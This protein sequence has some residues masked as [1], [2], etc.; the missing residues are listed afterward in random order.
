MTVEHYAL[1]DLIAV[2]AL[3]AADEHDTVRVEAHAGECAVCREELASLR[4]A[5]GALAVTVPQHEPSP[6]LKA[7]LMETVRAEAPARA[8]AAGIGTPPQP[9]RERARSRRPFRAFLRPWPV[10]AALGC[11][12]ALLLGWNIALQTG[13]DDPG[14][15]D[16]TALSVAGTADAPGVT[17][18]IVYVP[19]EDTAVVRLSRLPQ[20]EAGEAYQLW[21]LRDGQPPRSAGLFEQT[22]PA[23]ARSVASGSRG[24][25]AWP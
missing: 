24:A 21:I 19:G 12:A 22:G 4:A 11:V 1:R 3:G 7:S 25:T 16:V 10:V 13:S 9:R 14:R 18:R 15:G 23:E 5:A 6:A 2:V 17:G 20:L 8:L